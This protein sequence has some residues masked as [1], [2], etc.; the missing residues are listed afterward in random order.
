MRFLFIKLA[1]AITFIVIAFNALGEFGTGIETLKLSDFFSV[2]LLVMIPGINRNFTSPRE[3]L[4]RSQL[5]FKVF[6]YLKHL[7]KNNKLEAIV[8]LDIDDNS[9][10]SDNEDDNDVV[11]ANQENQNTVQS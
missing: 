9:S 1:F 8:K 11:N 4:K 3:N 2:I 6:K 7:D 5:Y 10:E